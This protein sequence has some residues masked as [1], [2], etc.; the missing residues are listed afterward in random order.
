[1][2]VNPTQRNPAS[3]SIPSP[4]VLSADRPQLACGMADTAALER[5]PTEQN[6]TDAHLDLPTSLERS[7]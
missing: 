5:L 3:E 7:L 4:G 1:M 2:E 6:R